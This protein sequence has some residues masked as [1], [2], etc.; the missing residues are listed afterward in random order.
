MISQKRPAPYTAGLLDSIETQHHSKKT[1]D[2][3]KE[4]CAMQNKPFLL[5]RDQSSL[6]SRPSKDT[7]YVRIRQVY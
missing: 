6:Q 2:L 5:N 1:H 3:A 4:T 7:A